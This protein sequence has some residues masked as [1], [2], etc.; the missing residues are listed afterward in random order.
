MNTVRLTMAQ[1]LVRWLM[2]QRTEID[3]VVRLGEHP[4]DV[5]LVGEVGANGQ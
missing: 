4:L 2:A 3:G 1:A 5:E